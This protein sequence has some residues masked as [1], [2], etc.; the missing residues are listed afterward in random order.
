[1]FCSSGAC[2]LYKVTYNLAARPPT[3]DLM[4]A[5][6]IRKRGAPLPQEL[7]YLHQFVRIAFKVH[8]QHSLAHWVNPIKLAISSHSSLIVASIY[9]IC[10][11][12]STPGALD[13]AGKFAEVHQ[14]IW[15]PPPE[16]DSGPCLLCLGS[17]QNPVWFLVLCLLAILHVHRPGPAG[18]RV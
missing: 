7:G 4:L 12:G 10:S 14:S 1:M 5:G 16:V 8:L 3:C 17:G 13:A 2:A 18:M 15:P 9:S 6:I 11:L